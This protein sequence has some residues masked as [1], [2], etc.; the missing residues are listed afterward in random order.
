MG[1]T[2]PDRGVGSPDGYP[3]MDRLGVISG[4][5]WDPVGR[6]CIPLISSCLRQLRIWGI[7]GPHS[8]TVGHTPLRRCPKRVKKGV[9]LGVTT[10]DGGSESQVGP[11]KWT[12]G[13]RLWR[14]CGPVG[15]WCTPL[16]SLCLR[17]LGIWGI[18]CH[19][20]PTLGQICPHLVQDGQKGVK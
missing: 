8:P 13:S 10:P 12:L 2:T 11:L 17:Q 19:Q 20:I 9:I 16:I 6:W 15:R 4:G 7:Y 14:V 3:K 5:V 18:Y 1:V